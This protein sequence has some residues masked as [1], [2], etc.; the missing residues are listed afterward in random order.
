MVLVIDPR[1]TRDLV[2]HRPA[3][4]QLI[5][6]GRNSNTALLI[7]GYANTIV[8][9]F[10]AGLDE[11]SWRAAAAGG[12]RHARLVQPAAL[13]RRWFIVP[14]IVALLTQVVT[15]L[16][17]GAVRRPRARGRHLRPAAGDA[18]AAGRYPPRQG[19]AGLVNRHQSRRP[20]SFWR[21]YGGS[22]IPLRGGLVPLYSGSCC[23]WSRSPASG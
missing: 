3:P 4:V 2:L 11:R 19:A 12:A 17:V 5:V 9:D 1:F 18:D 22:A 15:L 23:S 8:T 21:R 14:G 20:S 13:I 10:S 16:V 6:D 7:L